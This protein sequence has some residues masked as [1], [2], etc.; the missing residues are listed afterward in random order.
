MKLTKTLREAFV[1]AAMNDVPQTDYDEQAQKLVNEAAQK[2]FTDTFPGADHKALTDGGWL[3]QSWFGTPRG[4][5]NCYAYAPD[6]C[7][8]LHT[9]ELTQKL[10][11][12]S[13]AAM[14]QEKQ[15]DELEEKLNAVAY[16]VTTREALAKAL[17]EFEKYLPEAPDAVAK[18]LPAVANLV[19]DFTKA[20][21]PKGKEPAELLSGA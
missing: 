14:E 7:P 11:E 12:L 16:S 1:R 15:R 3:N 18:N 10:T 20:G 13:A 17:P 6:Y 4:L 8:Q 2:L 21:W 5:R 9:P 19:A